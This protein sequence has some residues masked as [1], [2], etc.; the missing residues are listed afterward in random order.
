MPSRSWSRGWRA[1]ASVSIRPTSSSCSVISSRSWMR[2][3]NRNMST[4]LVP[5]SNK[6]TNIRQLLE[7]SKGQIKL[8]L[9]AHLTPERMIRIAMTSIQKN[10]DLLNCTPQSLIGCV[11]QSAQLGLEPDSVLGH[12]YLVPFKTTCTFIIGYKGL[13]RL[14]RQSGEI[15]KIWSKVVYANDYFDYEE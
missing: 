2:W 13:Q 6:I 5:V 1:V 9:P 10:S 8:A 7:K 11:I 4:E 12:A 3:R 14:A 15:S